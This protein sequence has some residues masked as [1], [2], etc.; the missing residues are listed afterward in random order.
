MHRKCLTGEMEIERM[1]REQKNVA[2]NY[3]KQREKKRATAKQ[4][5]SEKKNEFKLRELLY[6]YE[7]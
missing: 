4:M 3:L 7:N 1:N 2:L 5:E 6:T